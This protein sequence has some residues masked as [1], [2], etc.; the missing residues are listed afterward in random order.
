MNMII[1]LIFAVLLFIIFFSRLA[2]ALWSALFLGL[3]L[4]LFTAAPFGVLTASWLISLF[5]SNLLFNY[6]FTNRSLPAFLALGFCGAL[7][8]QAVFFFLNLLVSFKLPLLFSLTLTDYASLSLRSLIFN[9]LFLLAIFI[10]ASLFSK[11][12][13]SV[14]LVR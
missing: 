11:K 14:F 1:N 13:K 9:E 5:L 8:F 2:P 10:I 3:L 4:E 6:F 7:I 12:L